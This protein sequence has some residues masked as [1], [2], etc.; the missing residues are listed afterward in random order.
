MWESHDTDCDFGTGAGNKQAGT[1][2]RSNFRYMYWTMKQQLA[3]HTVTGCN[4]RPGDLLASG[5]I[6][7]P[8]SETFSICALLSRLVVLSCV[9]GLTKYNY[10][11]LS[12]S[13]LKLEN[14]VYVFPVH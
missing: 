6:S 2:C 8:V 10:S 12:C 5:T 14:E 9:A 1:V 4:M 13:F 7:G 11:M 3:H